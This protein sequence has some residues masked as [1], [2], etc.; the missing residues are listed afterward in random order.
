MPKYPF[1]PC[2]FAYLLHKKEGKGSN[3]LGIYALNLTYHSLL[4]VVLNVPMLILMLSTI[5]CDYGSED[6]EG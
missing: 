4:N 3:Y 2:S 1:K 6:V 5:P